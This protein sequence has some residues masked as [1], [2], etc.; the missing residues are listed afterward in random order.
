MTATTLFLLIY[1]LL[2]LLITNNNNP[3]LCTAEIH[4]KAEQE[5]SHTTRSTSHEYEHDYR[6]YSIQAC[7]YCPKQNL[8]QSDNIN[9]NININGADDDSLQILNQLVTSEG[10]YYPSMLEACLDR[11]RVEIFECSLR[12]ED[13]GD[14]S[15]S[16]STTT[17]TF[18]QYYKPCKLTSGDESFRM[19]EMQVVLVI[20]GFYA[21]KSVKRQ[22]QLHL[23]LFDQRRTRQASA[24]SNPNKDAS[25]G[26]SSS[27]S[28]SSSEM[29]MLIRNVSQHSSRSG[30]N[31]GSAHGLVS[32]VV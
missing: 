14:A 13:D 2:L 19:F 28:S 10:Y 23:S 11:G 16:N 3:I 31:N 1:P 17:T 4:S 5:S 15:A 7:E 21:V 30:T 18:A 12:N 27:V 26:A 9:I 8:L 32:S 20:V 6:C 25:N 24:S 22:K 29:E